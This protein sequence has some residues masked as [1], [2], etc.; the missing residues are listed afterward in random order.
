MN[1]FSRWVSWV[2]FG[3]LSF[4]EV[5]YSTMRPLPRSFP[6]ASKDTCRIILTAGNLELRREARLLKGRCLS[7]SESIGAKAIG[8][9][10]KLRVIKKQLCSYG[11]CTPVGFALSENWHGIP[12]PHRPRDSKSARQPAAHLR[13]TAITFVFTPAHFASTACPTF[14]PYSHV[15]SRSTWAIRRRCQGL[16][17]HGSNVCFK[18]AGSGS[19][20]ILPRVF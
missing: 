3:F 7:G 20:F 6:N 4:L 19:A 18:V 10:I 15:S 14:S 1:Y 2:L 16:I 17:C 9:V 11:V 5:I 13:M 12:S 8:E